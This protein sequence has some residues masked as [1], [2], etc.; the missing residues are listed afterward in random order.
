MLKDWETAPKIDMFESPTEAPAKQETPEAPMM[1][2]D[3]DAPKKEEVALPVVKSKINPVNP[4]GKRDDDAELAAIQRESPDAYGI[5]KALLMKKQMGLPLPGAEAAANAQ[6]AREQMA[7]ERQQNPDATTGH[8]NNM[9]N[10]KPQNSASD[11]IAVTQ[12]MS[13]TV[14]A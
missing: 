10:W 1:A 4:Y 2:G 7:G 9:W 3:E 5:V 8:I 14:E 12:E 13:D 11:E 6:S